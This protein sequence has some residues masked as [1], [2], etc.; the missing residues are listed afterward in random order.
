MRYIFEKREDYRGWSRRGEWEEMRFRVQKGFQLGEDF[1]FLFELV[2]KL[3]DGLTCVDKCLGRYKD[4][5][6]MYINR[7]MGIF[8]EKFI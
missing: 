7:Y 4:L 2:G 6:F 3:Y 1:R 5:K 8:I